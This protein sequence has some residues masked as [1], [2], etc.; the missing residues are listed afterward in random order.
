MTSNVVPG[1]GAAVEALSLDLQN[2]RIQLVQ[3]NA[4]RATVCKVPWLLFGCLRLRLSE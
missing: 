3:G 2:S 4:V 1:V